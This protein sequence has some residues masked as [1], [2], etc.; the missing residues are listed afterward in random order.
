M[1]ALMP[2]LSSTDTTGSVPACIRDGAVK[3]ARW[4]GFIPLDEAKKKPGLRPVRL[5]TQRYSSGDRFEWT[6]VKP[7]EY[8][9][10]CLTEEGVYAVVTSSI[11]IVCPSRA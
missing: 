11:P 3:Y 7:G 8:V 4:P 2:T 1:L 5:E 6:D 9:Q 10:G